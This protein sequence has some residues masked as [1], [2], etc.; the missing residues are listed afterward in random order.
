MQ[1]FV[2]TM[3]IS[4]LLLTKLSFY[5]TPSGGA[6]DDNITYTYTTDPAYGDGNYVGHY[7]D[8][9]S[10]TWQHFDNLDHIRPD[11]GVPAINRVGVWNLPGRDF[12]GPAADPVP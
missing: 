4:S 10:P 3:I 11:T 5:D 9:W 2:S 7:T 1:S 6:W 8:L 12:P